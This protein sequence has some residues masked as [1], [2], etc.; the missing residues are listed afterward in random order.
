MFAICLFSAFNL[1]GFQLGTQ[2][3]QVVELT[4]TT[5]E[6]LEAH[7]QLMPVKVFGIIKDMN[8]Y[9]QVITIM[10]GRTVTYVQHAAQTREKV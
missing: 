4:L 5:D 9:L 6:P 10:D 8:L 3:I 7:R 2:L 1:V